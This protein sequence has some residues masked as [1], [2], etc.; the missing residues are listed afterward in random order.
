MIVKDHIIYVWFNPTNFFQSKEDTNCISSEFVK[1]KII[2]FPILTE[3]I[4]YKL[5]THLCNLF[6]NFHQMKEE[7]AKI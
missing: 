3:N 2:D 1:C 5:I 6:V 7:Q 4:L